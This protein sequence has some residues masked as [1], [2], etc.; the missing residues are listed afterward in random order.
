MRRLVKSTFKRN[1]AEGDPSGASGAGEAAGPSPSGGSGGASRRD[2]GGGVGIGRAPS[3][4]ERS[5]PSSQAGGG[6]SRPGAPGAARPGAGPGAGGAAGVPRGGGAVGPGGL[7]VPGVLPG[8]RPRSP[9]GE[10]PA[11]GV[12]SGAGGAG[13]PGSP[14]AGG[15][16]HHGGHTSSDADD[17]ARRAAF[18][19]PLPSFQDVPPAERQALFLRKLKLCSFRMDFSDPGLD[20]VEKEAR[21]GVAPR[22][23]PP[24]PSN[25]HVFRSMTLTLIPAPG[26]AADAGRAG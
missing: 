26:Q 16:G 13:G 2:A 10:K 20:V 8:Q 12:S 19:V 21:R 14:G 9:H 25:H 22:P 1:G 18:A 15:V 7:A 3:G 11:D 17:E 23:F 5:T 24:T 4:R 6:A